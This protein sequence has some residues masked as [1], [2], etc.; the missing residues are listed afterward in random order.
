MK[1]EIVCGSKTMKK[2]II[3]FYYLIILS[4]LRNVYNKITFNLFILMHSHILVYT[5]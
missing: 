5:N 2:K 3:E 1:H 4:Q